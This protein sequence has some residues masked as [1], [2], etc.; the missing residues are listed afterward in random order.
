MH[1]LADNGLLIKILTYSPFL[2]LI[3][4]PDSSL[5]QLSIKN[6]FRINSSRIK[7]LVIE[8]E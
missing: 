7:V 6:I 3:I 4:Q 1:E 5:I 2:D 8:L